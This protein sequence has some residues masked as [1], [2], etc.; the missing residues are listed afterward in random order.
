MAG[1]MAR[2]FFVDCLHHLSFSEPNEQLR[3]RRS[4]LLVHPQELRHV[5]ELFI[6]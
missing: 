4:A 1:A 3:D 5:A 6:S 2:R